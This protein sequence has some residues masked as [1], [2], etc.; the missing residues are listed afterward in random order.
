MTAGRDLR[1]P[2]RGFEPADVPPHRVGY[3][4]IGLAA[5][6]ALSAILVAGML[7]LIA[8]HAG[9]PA[10]DRL[11]TRPVEP[12]PPRLEVRRDGDRAAIEAAARAK[13]EGF[14]WTDRAA[15]RAHIP[16]ARAMGLTARHGWPDDAPGRSP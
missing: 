4:L 13:L 7:V 3:A 9:H 6:V 10:P 12:P 16:I 1:A 15:G 11:A 14:G 8:R 2:E 5:C